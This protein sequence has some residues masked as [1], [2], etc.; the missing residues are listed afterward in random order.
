VY[1]ENANL[2]LGDL[3]FSQGDGELSFCG[4]I[5]MVRSKTNETLLT[6]QA[7]V[8]TLKTSIIKDGVAKLGLKQPIFTVRLLYRLETNVSKAFA[9]R[10][11][12]QGANHLRGHLCW[13][14]SHRRS[15]G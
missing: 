5:E 13:W 7:G 14:V 6:I 12:V 8:V 11:H 15:R 10:S 1:V 3:H 2:A 9:D 4:A